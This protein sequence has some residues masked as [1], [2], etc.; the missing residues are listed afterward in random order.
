LEYSTD[1][2]ITWINIANT[3]TTQGYSNLMATTMYQ[4]RVGNGV[5]PS[6]TSLPATITVDPMVLGGTV[7]GSTTVCATGNAGSLMLAGSSGTIVTWETSNDGGVTWVADGNTTT[8]ENYLNLIDTTWYR[9]ILM[10]GTCG[11]DTSTI[12][13]IMVDPPTVGGITSANALV[14]AGVNGAVIHLTGDTGSVLHWEF[15]TDGGNNWIAVNNTTDSL[16]YLNLTQTTE[17]RALVQSGVCSPALY[18]STD[19]ITVSPMT[20]GGTISGSTATCEGTGNG[21]LTLSGYV[22]TILGW[23]TSTDGGL[24]WSPTPNNTDTLSWTN[25]ADTVW[26]HVLVSSGA[27]G[28]D[29]LLLLP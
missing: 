16:T 7:T 12:G 21:L 14:C 23:E 27:C 19:T 22:A 8:T 11:N 1:G 17:Y 26:Y 6:V 2:G 24:T 28:L 3:T 9:A 4:A 15:S 20:V 29:T 5:C 13:V 18:S 10:S 25:P